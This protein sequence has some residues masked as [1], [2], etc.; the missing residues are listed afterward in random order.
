[1]KCTVVMDMPSDCMLQFD[2]RN[3]E[4]GRNIGHLVFTESGISWRKKRSEKFGKVINWEN[5]KNLIENN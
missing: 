1:M 4:T 2:V 3:A 5:V